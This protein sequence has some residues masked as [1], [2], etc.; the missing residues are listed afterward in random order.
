V[1]TFTDSLKVLGFLACF[2]IGIPLLI[3][4][5]MIVLEKL[6]RVIDRIDRR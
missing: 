1:N 6:Q 3:V 2:V 5:Y 4:A